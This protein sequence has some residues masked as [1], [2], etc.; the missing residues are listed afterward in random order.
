MAPPPAT[1]LPRDSARLVLRDT[2]AYFALANEETNELVLRVE[3][4]AA[5]TVKNGESHTI[6]FPLSVG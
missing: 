6:T 3:L 2:R 4:H 1:P 5:G